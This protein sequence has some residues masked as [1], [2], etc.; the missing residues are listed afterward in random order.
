[1]ALRGRP[2][3]DQQSVVRVAVDVFNQHGHDATPTGIVAGF[4]GISRS[5]ICHHVPS[6]GEL[7]RLSLEPALVA[8]KDIPVQLE[9]VDGPAGMRLRSV[10]RQMVAVFADQLPAGTLLL[11]LLGNT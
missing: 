4:L 8:L 1:M 3:Y 9:A 5:A 6:K 2:G 7:L 11:R 10:L